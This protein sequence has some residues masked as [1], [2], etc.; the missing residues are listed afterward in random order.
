MTSHLDS[1]GPTDIKPEMLSGVQTGNEIQHNEYNTCSI[2]HVHACR[3]NNIFMQRQ[4]MQSF[5]YIWIVAHKK[6]DP[7]PPKKEEE[8]ESNTFKE[9]CPCRNYIQ[10]LHYLAFAAFILPVPNCSQGMFWFW[11]L[12]NQAPLKGLSHEDLSWH[13]WRKKLSGTGWAWWKLWKIF[14]SS[15]FLTFSSK[16]SQLMALKL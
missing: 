8:E 12:C 7:L 5:T 10:N 11:Q 4:L 9:S 3:K 6:I 14:F 15:S 16:S 1:H 13:K 2:A